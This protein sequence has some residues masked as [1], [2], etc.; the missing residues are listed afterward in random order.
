MSNFL[1]EDKARR[2]D[3]LRKWLKAAKEKNLAVDIKKLNAVFMTDYG[4]LPS[5]LHRYLIELESAGEIEISKDG[6]TLEVI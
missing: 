1:M 4:I 6:N 3:L 5:L 2:M